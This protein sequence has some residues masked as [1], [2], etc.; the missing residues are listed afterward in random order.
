MNRSAANRV[1][2]SQYL[3]LSQS[4]FDGFSYI[5]RELRAASCEAQGLK[6]RDQT[7]DLEA[8]SS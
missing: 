6:F 3:V 4:Y 2:K 5:S 8:H 1:S 7:I